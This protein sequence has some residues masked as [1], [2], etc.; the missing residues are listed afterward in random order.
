MFP[1]V[2]EELS[3]SIH[4]ALN[5]PRLNT[6][7]DMN[8]PHYEATITRIRSELCWAKTSHD[9]HV[10]P[11]TEISSVTAGLLYPSDFSKLQRRTSEKLGKRKE[12]EVV[13]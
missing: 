13:L 5:R 12:T 8:A 3:N 6:F 7:A 11:H 4:G 2:V 1:I 9:N 10:P